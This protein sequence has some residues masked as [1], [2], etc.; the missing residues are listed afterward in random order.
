M[1][2]YGPLYTD[3]EF[4]TIHLNLDFQGMEKVREA[5]TAEDY[6]LA[7]HRYADFIRSHLD[8]ARYFSVLYEKP[9]NVIVAEGESEMEAAERICR[10][11][12]ISCGT[13]Y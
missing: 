3:Q 5:V 11:C 13:P 6:G 10:N 8:P 9:C 4:F 1:E 12:L 7:R 2:Q